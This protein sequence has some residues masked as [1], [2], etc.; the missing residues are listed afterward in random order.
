M[1]QT[2]GFFKAMIT[3]LT[4][5]E[6]SQADKFFLNQEDNKKNSKISHIKET[7]LGIPDVD[8]LKKAECLVRCYIVDAFDLAAKDEDTNSDPYLKIQLGDIV[9]DE[10]KN[11]QQD[12]PNPV[13]NKMYEFP[14]TL[15]GAGLL[16]ITVMDSD[17]FA[18]D[19]MIGEAIID[20]EDRWFSKKFRQLQE[21]PIETRELRNPQ[22][23][24]P[25]G[26]LRLFVDIIPREENL[27]KK[28]WD[29]VNKPSEVQLLLN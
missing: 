18:K 16:R 5:E 23:R 15:P 9:I 19:D 29:I 4:E 6:K 27:T 24:M 26:Y 7:V 12:E 28:K 11:P 25:Q 10:H 13:F 21:V 20:V 1:L 3:V 22:S 2:V 17:D 8:F 14:C